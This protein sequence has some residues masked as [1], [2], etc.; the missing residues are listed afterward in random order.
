MKYKSK[1]KNADPIGNVRDFYLIR[2]RKP[3]IQNAI[4][5]HRHTQH[6][7]IL[8]A[9]KDMEEAREGDGRYKQIIVRVDVGSG[10]VAE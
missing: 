8:G 7:L 4:A 10:G 2:R 1:G 9:V 6:V 5:I 3:R